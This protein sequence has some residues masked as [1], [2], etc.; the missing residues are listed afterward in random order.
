VGGGNT[1][2]TESGNALEGFAGLSAGG[3]WRL[4]IVDDAGGDTGTVNSWSLVIDTV[5]R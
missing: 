4:D 3:E 2:R 1:Y 5:R